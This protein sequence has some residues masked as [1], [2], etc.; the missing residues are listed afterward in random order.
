MAQ[1][2]SD[3]AHFKKITRH[4]VRA[5]ANDM[6][7]M[8]IGGCMNKWALDQAR[9][10]LLV[11]LLALTGVTTPA[12]YAIEL[13]A[14]VDFS[15]VWRVAT[16]VKE[17]RTV[18]GK[19]PPLLPDAKKIYEQRKAQL[20]KGDKSFDLAST[21]CKP[22]GEPRIMYESKQFP[23]EIL[24]TDRQVFFGYQW[25][26]LI[27]YIQ[28]NKPQN[29]L[30]PLYF[31]GSEGKWEG[32]TL[33]AEVQGLHENVT[34]DAAGMP[35]SEDIRMTERYSLKNNGKQMQVRITFND[36]AT[37]SKPWDAVFNFDKVPGGQ[38]EEDVCV[39]RIKMFK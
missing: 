9:S 1:N 39:E 17:L 21:Q 35:H 27:R 28:M 16:E 37:F 12:S 13:K 18:E 8:A 38:I 23:F 34:L 5:V 32:T 15:G 6:T 2:Q 14:P 33:V 10:Q 26:R 3:R 20:K 31:G 4:N 30:I 24:Q 29:V 22:L 36:P 25:N 7:V 11:A 19:E